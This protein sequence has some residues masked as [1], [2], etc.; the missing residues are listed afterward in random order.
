VGAA[1]HRTLTELPAGEVD[2]AV[3]LLSRGRRVFALGGWYSQTLAQYLV[4]LLQVARPGVTLVGPT[5]NE[6]TALAV[7][8]SR[9]DVVCVFDFRRY[10]DASLRMARDVKARHGTVI[11]LT[12]QWLCPVAE[13]ADVVLPTTIVTPGRF[14][15]LTPAMAVVELL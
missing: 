14:E 4:S 5:P 12:D 9:S 7:D 8:A 1:L 11:L 3:R 15:S 2:R 10:E 13:V 6:R